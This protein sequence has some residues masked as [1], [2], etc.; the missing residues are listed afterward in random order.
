M[1]MLI[2]T[3]KGAKADVRVDYSDRRDIDLGR[4]DGVRQMRPETDEDMFDRQ[5]KAAGAESWRVATGPTATELKE[6]ATQKRRGV[7]LGG[8]VVDVGGAR[9]ETWAD[10]NTVAALAAICLVGGGVHW[11]GRVETQ[12]LDGEQAFRLLH[13]INAF[14]Q[15]ARSVEVATHKAIES[16]NVTAID[17]VMAAAWPSN[18]AIII[19]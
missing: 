6:A 5:A 13:G 7:I 15:A 2:A 16:G 18:D 8:C 4:I 12:P 14:V 17:H 3:V 11:K 10:Q 19:G 1:T 9:V